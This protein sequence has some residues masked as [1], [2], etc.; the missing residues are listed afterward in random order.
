MT[1]QGDRYDYQV[2]YQSNGYVWPRIVRDCASKEE[3]IQRAELPS[4]AMNVKVRRI[5]PAARAGSQEEGSG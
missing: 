4:G 1:E 3:A 2:S 5:A